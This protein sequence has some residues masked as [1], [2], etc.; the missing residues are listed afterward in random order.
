MVADRSEAVVITLRFADGRAKRLELEPRA[1]GSHE[2]TERVLTK[3]GQFRPLGT[4]IVDSLS[5]DR[6]D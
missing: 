1:D 6:P 4:E 3:G 5:I 2:L